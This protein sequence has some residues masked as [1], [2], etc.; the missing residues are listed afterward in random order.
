MTPR[1]PGPK[2]VMAKRPTNVYLLAHQ[3]M[4][5]KLACQATGRDQSQYIRHALEMQLIRDG[6]PNEVVADNDSVV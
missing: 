3:T 6:Q 1:K 2:P 5:L 4:R